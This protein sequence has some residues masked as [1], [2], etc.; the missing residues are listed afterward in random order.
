MIVLQICPGEEVVEPLGERGVLL[1]NGDD[2]QRSSTGAEQQAVRREQRRPFVSVFEWL[3][4]G[5]LDEQIQCVLLGIGA[6]SRLLDQVLQGVVRDGIGNVAT[7]AGLYDDLL[8]RRT[9]L[10]RM[11]GTSP[12][13]PG[14]FGPGA[15][16]GCVLL[17]RDTTPVSLPRRPCRASTPR[18][19]CPRRTSG[20]K[21]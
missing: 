5:D 3:R 1:V 9:E 20:G 2:Q 18:P 13:D 11:Q 17:S 21:H 15:A 6:R 10:P 16:L 8:L 4:F 7:V 14:P 19:P 12:G